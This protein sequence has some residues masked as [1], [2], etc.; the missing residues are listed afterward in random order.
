MPVQTI[1]AKILFLPWK[2]PLNMY[3]YT[4]NENN[5]VIYV[6]IKRTVVSVSSLTVQEEKAVRKWLIYAEFRLFLFC[7]DIT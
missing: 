4:R 6:I 7:T 1:P 2:S 5:S 3:H